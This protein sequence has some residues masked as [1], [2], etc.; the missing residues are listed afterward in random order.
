MEQNG[1][2]KRRWLVWGL[3]LVC[4]VVL[5]L[6]LG[7]MCCQETE[8]EDLLVDVYE[9]DGKHPV[10]EDVVVQFHWTNEG[11]EED[12]NKKEKRLRRF[13]RFR[14]RAENGDPE[15]MRELAYCYE[16]G[17]GVEQNFAEAA[18]WFRQ[19]A[20]HGN[21][22]A[23]FYWGYYCETGQG[24]KQNLPEA[25]KWYDQAA[26]LGDKE[27][28]FSLIECYAG[29]K[30]VEQ[31]FAKADKMLWKGYDPPENFTETVDWYTFR[32]TDFIRGFVRER[33]FKPIRQ[34]RR[35]AKRGDAKAQFA[36]GRYYDLHEAALQHPLYA[37]K[38]YCRSAVQG[39][40]PAMLALGEWYETHHVGLVNMYKWY[41]RAAEQGYA[42]AMVRL[43]EL[44][45]RRNE[46]PEASEW[47]Q[48]AVTQGY[49]PA[50]V[51]LGEFYDDGYGNV[52]RVNFDEAFKWSHKAAE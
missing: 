42:P 23:M 13:E 7:L 26:K 19:S 17:D 46:L 50:M 3:A 6:G 9:T 14:Q 12:S 49:T 34:Y 21:S 22:Y 10:I 5:G 24:G 30:G 31:N 47:F 29:G 28:L 39:Y 16:D 4:C 38:W 52:F 1:N 37:F 33:F 36:L 32:V 51:E 35:A 43:G 44:Y 11:K 15:A 45:I 48:K 2:T 18:K 20:E 8:V 25:V 41:R 40:A 27:A